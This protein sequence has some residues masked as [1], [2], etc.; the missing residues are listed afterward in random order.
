MQITRSM[1]SGPFACRIELIDL[2]SV[3]KN[4]AWTPRPSESQLEAD[5]RGVHPTVFQQALDRSLWEFG[6]YLQFAAKSHHDLLQRRNM[7]VALLFQFRQARLL[8]ARRIGHLLLTL[9]GQLPVFTEQQ[10]PEQFLRAAG[11]LSSPT[12]ER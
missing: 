7:H 1:R 11:R 3:L 10:L 8:D 5:G 6:Q 4:V 2:N 9:A 12:R